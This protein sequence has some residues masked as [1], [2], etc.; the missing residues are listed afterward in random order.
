MEL[1]FRVLFAKIKYVYTFARIAN[2]EYGI[3]N[4]IL[5]IHK[6]MSKHRPAKISKALQKSELIKG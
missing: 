1:E 3:D 5:P 4:V 6:T 2:Y